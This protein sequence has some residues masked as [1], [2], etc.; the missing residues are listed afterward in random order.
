TTT[1]TT[2]SETTTE[3]TTTTTLTTTSETTTESTT[4]TTPSTTLETSTEPTTTT[5]PT[6][7]LETTTEPPTTT[8]PTITLETTTEPP[9][10]T[11]PTTTSETTTEPPTT[12]TT[13]ATSE[14]ATEPTTTTTPSTTALTDPCDELECTASEWCGERNGVYGCLCSEEHD[15][16]SAEYFDSKEICNGSSATISLSRCQ[17][18]QSG[19]PSNSL[20]LNDPNCTGTVRDGRVEFHFDSDD[21]ICGTTLTSNGTHLIYQNTIHGETYPQQATIRREKILSVTFYC[22]YLL[23]QSSSMS[24][25]I[26]PL[27]S[28]LG[29]NLPAGINRYQMRMIP[30]LDAQFQQPF[31]GSTMEVP[32]NQQVYVAVE[33][34]GLDDRQIATVIDSCWAT[35]INDPLSSVRWDLIVQECPNPADGT[36]E[37]LQNGVSTS[38][39]FSFKMLTFTSNTTTTVFLHCQI[40]LCVLSGNNCST[41]CYPGNQ[42]RVRRAVKFRDTSS[43]SIGPFVLQQTQT[44]MRALERISV[45]GAPASLSSLLPLMLSVVAAVVLH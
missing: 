15:N 30:Y 23:S 8:T 1:P 7:T 33:V 14:T 22:V 4:T 27:Q 20:H 12:T 13:T 32:I 36:V 2:T 24:E 21:H 10:T 45:A 18:F 37:I 26:Y 31:T 34:E 40:H 19:F 28:I 38:S 44:D 11:T 16:T 3:P 17:L 6:T 35:P 43:M 9:T 5:T 39:R 25:D 29:K 41:S 42:Q